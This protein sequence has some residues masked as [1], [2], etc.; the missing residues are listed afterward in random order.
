MSDEFDVVIEDGS[1]ESVAG[2]IVKIW[3]ETEVGKQQLLL[4]FEELADALKDKK[5]VAQEVPA[6][7]GDEDEWE[8]EDSDEDVDMSEKDDEEAPRLLQH[9]ESSTHG[10][11]VDEDG[12]TL[13]KGKG[14][15]RR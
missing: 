8:D 12:F 4:K 15:N 11:E 14:K 6:S 10:P 7:E 5:V 2:D 1:A 13:V 3:E 9:P